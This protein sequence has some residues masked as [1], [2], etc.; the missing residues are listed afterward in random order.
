M[1]ATTTPDNQPASN[2]AERKA[3][4]A[5]PPGSAISF[6]IGDRTYWVGRDDRRNG[7]RIV[8]N[9]DMVDYAS[10]LHYGDI[11]AFQRIVERLAAIERDWAYSQ[12]K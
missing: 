12:N 3:G 11:G 5:A 10:A 8:A 6:V 7:Y 9:G 4:F 2:E 1:N